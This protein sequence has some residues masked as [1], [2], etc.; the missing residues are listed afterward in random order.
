MYQ[1]NFP[2]YTKCLSTQDLGG[3][4]KKYCRTKLFQLCDFVFISAL[5]QRRS[6]IR[7]TASLCY[8]LNFTERVTKILSVKC[9]TKTLVFK[10]KPFLQKEV[11]P[12]N[13]GLMDQGSKLIFFYSQSVLVG[14]GRFL[15]QFSVK[16]QK[17]IFI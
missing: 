5:I 1:F 8:H 3:N 16:V 11:I 6:L 2:F 12:K 17:Y 7:A 15:I 14:L 13:F 9:E 10:S 4:P